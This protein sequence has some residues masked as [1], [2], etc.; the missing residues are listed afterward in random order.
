MPIFVFST[1]QTINADRH[2]NKFSAED[3]DYIIID[4]SHHAGASTY[5][6]VLNHF[7]PKF[8]LGMTATPERTDGFDIFSLFDH[9]VAYEIRLKHALENGIACPFSLFWCIRFGGRW[10]IDR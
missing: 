1:V 4:E 3:F 5:L 2:I 6:R 10:D 9:S 7:K 8:L